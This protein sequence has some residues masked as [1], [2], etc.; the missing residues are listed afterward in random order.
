VPAG[1]AVGRRLGVFHQHRAQGRLGMA[2]QPRGLRMLQRLPPGSAKVSHR[3]ERGTGRDGARQGKA[4]PRHSGATWR[5]VGGAQPQH[6]GSDEV[7]QFSAES[8]HVN[9]Q[10]QACQAERGNDRPC[11][12]QVGDNG[13]QRRP[14]RPP[15]PAQHPGTQRAGARRV[16]HQHRR[17]GHRASPPSGSGPRS[18]CSSASRSSAASCGLIW[19]AKCVSAV[20]R[21][22]LVASA[23]FIS[24]AV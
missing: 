7:T 8:G 16:R 10:R 3:G 9:R 11:G 21:S 19:S 24:A 6:A 5:S 15:G 23:S 1:N 22:G 20:R 17:N 14:S 4:E 13:Q 2:D 12:G 18:A